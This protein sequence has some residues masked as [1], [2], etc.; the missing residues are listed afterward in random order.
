ML[1]TRNM[2]VQSLSFSLYFCIL[3]F[4]HIPSL[5]IVAD[6]PSIS[7]E[8]H[9]V[10][11]LA[12][13]GCSVD[14]LE[15][16]E[17]EGFGSCGP[18]PD[19]QSLMSEWLCSLLENQS[20]NGVILGRKI[21]ILYALEMVKN[22]MKLPI[23]ETMTIYQMLK[24]VER[25][26]LGINLTVPF[27]EEMQSHYQ[28]IISHLFGLFHFENADL[29]AISLHKKLN[30][31][32]YAIYL[33]RLIAGEPFVK[34][35]P[36]TWTCLIH[37]II[38]QIRYFQGDKRLQSLTKVQ[39]D[40]IEERLVH[41]LLHCLFK[42]FVLMSIS[43]SKTANILLTEFGVE[44]SSLIQYEPF[45][46]QWREMVRNLTIELLAII[47]PKQEE[48][49]KNYEF[50][51][52]NKT[53]AKSKGGAMNRSIGIVQESFDMDDGSFYFGVEDRLKLLNVDVLEFGGLD[54]AFM[55]WDR[56]LH[57]LG[58]PAR[59]PHDRTRSVHLEGFCDALKIF[60]CALG[61][62][63][64]GAAR[65]KKEEAIRLM[66]LKQNN[67]A[68]GLHSG[69]HG[70]NNN[71]HHST[72]GV[73]GNGG[74]A[75]G[76]LSGVRRMG[77]SI[78]GFAH[79]LI[80]VPIDVSSISLTGNLPDSI[81]NHLPLPPREQLP[82]SDTLMEIF[83]PWLFDECLDILVKCTYTEQVNRL[84]EFKMAFGCLAAIFL[85]KCEVGYL[86]AFAE[87][88]LSTFYRIIRI[89]FGVK[90]SQK[91]RAMVLEECAKGCLFG[92]NLRGVNC[93]IPDFLK[94]ME[95]VVGFEK[96]Q[97]HRYT[98]K[99]HKW[100]VAVFHEQEAN[101]ALTIGM[102]LICFA[103]HFQSL[104]IVPFPNLKGDADNDNDGNDGNGTAS[105]SKTDEPDGDD[106]I[107]KFEEI[108]SRVCDVFFFLAH[109][110]NLPL[111]IV[112]TVIWGSVLL[113]YDQVSSTKDLKIISCAIK[114]IVDGTSVD[115]LGMAEVATRA[116]ESLSPIC[117]QIC[118]IDS[119]LV[120][121]KLFGPF[122]QNML[123]FVKK[124]A[125]QDLRSRK[126]IC[127]VSTHQIYCCLEWMFRFPPSV[128][129]NDTLMSDYFRVLHESL[130]LQTKLPHKRSLQ[131]N[132]ADK[133]PLADLVLAAQTSKMMLFH[134]L[135]NFP[136]PHDSGAI[137]SNAMDDYK[138]SQEGNVFLAY[139]SNVLITAN[140]R[141]L[142]HQ[143]GPEPGV[144]FLL[145]DESGKFAWNFTPC[146]MESRPISNVAE[147][148]NDAVP[149]L[150]PKT[151]LRPMSKS[152][153]APKGVLQ[154]NAVDPKKTTT[155]TSAPSSSSTSRPAPPPPTVTVDGGPST[156]GSRSSPVSPHSP[157]LRRNV[158]YKKRFD[159]EQR[160]R[161][162]PP[163][164]GPPSQSKEGKKGQNGQN[165]SNSQ[166]AQTARIHN[167]NV[168]LT[169][170]DEKLA[171]VVDKKEF[172]MRRDGDNKVD[173]LK[174]VLNYVSRELTPPAGK[175]S[176]T[177]SYKK[178]IRP[179][180]TS[181]SNNA[182]AA[183][184]SISSF[185]GS[186]QP[187][188]SGSG[189][190]SSKMSNKKRTNSGTF[191]SGHMTD[192]NRAK[193]AKYMEEQRRE[194][195]ELYRVYEK[196]REQQLQ[197]LRKLE[198]ISV[199]EDA[200]G[201][202]NAET[203]EEG[204]KSTAVS[205]AASARNELKIREAVTGF[206]CS[207]FLLGH[208]GIL[209][210]GHVLGVKDSLFSDVTSDDVDM[211]KSGK[212]SVR[213]TR[214]M[215]PPGSSSGDGTKPRS[216]AMMGTSGSGRSHKD[217]K[218][219]H[220]SFSSSSGN[221][222]PPRQTSGKQYRLDPY[223]Y[224]LDQN[225]LAMFGNGDKTFHRRTH[226]LDKSSLEREKHKIGVVYVG[227]DQDEQRLILANESGSISYRRFID[228]LGWTVDL[229]RH[230]GFNGAMNASTTGR[231][232]KYYCTATHEMAFH[233]AT[234]MPTNHSDPQ[235][236]EKK[237]HIGNDQVNIIWTDSGR[238]YIIDTIYSHFNQAQI[239]I[240]PLN[241]GLYRIKIHRKAD[242][243]E[244][245]P[246]RNNMIIRE[247]LLSILVRITSLYA[248]RTIRYAASVYTRPFVERKKYLDEAI[249]KNSHK[250]HESILGAFFPYMAASATSA[251]S[252]S[253]SSFST[254]TSTRR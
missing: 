205:T 84:G 201:D 72:L 80:S 40:A 159:K 195:M 23:S 237:K 52:T 33:L 15:N 14:K 158:G 132:V 61:I 148:A 107:A 24:R 65:K 109:F 168:T 173:G 208:L 47:S 78:Y 199:V 41:P 225:L 202:G 12:L 166:N 60:L 127:A 139:D 160:D 51:E 75:V 63:E 247:H 16:V 95:S 27:K 17:R 90:I 20:K 233:I 171:N 88:Y 136:L 217:R 245:G 169:K 53:A 83:G 222:H 43:D 129:L 57:L 110:D 118:D 54:E 140:D 100:S 85:T 143:A 68:N 183:T 116:I 190:G 125:N 239:V 234:K 64:R 231:Y 244:F 174:Q 175:V 96:M 67:M 26:I 167:F 188:G 221:P 9:T 181:S 25:W 196:Q 97:Q 192:K 161:P 236:T 235:Q 214:P 32:S 179:P 117:N 194:E 113:I 186:P 216:S 242:V 154:S 157:S 212:S 149:V 70:N 98:A 187:K 37:G 142:A 74:T 156:Q 220:A 172:V 246:L 121:D 226:L 56:M 44:T 176:K 101:D 178:R 162:S 182:A 211:S 249:E 150:L 36:E 251:S 232:A 103:A 1:M 111:S 207:R 252:S 50:H 114:A 22:T 4:Y 31:I 164:P 93:L 229:L 106:G 35:S 55:I 77:S 62:K 92:K 99:R 119:Q 184:S 185:S 153:S 248:N 82:Q 6:F 8:K 59:N 76:G 29:N 215:S 71:H 42:S 238:E 10:N 3:M 180:T 7:A 120:T 115:K 46:I 240:Y 45:V 87:L 203:K 165:E 230:E 104:D 105:E 189:S 94:A 177:R 89:S 123:Q 170:T 134:Y 126:E 19:I 204:A 223:L 152:Q 213:R 11:I 228:K 86:G 151:M 66:K 39:S 34:L 163:R 69:H 224:S 193:L 210:P 227:P 124:A 58:S 49:E 2:S 102:S 79:S 5:F 133:H 28:R 206:D 112:N 197:R 91:I 38:Q 241:N 200:D 219:R 253:H 141:I 18:P 155:T 131:Q 243:G 135:G 137:S 146:S 191:P 138:G 30:I 130:C 48:K 73:P 144:R 81:R 13:C 147:P 218:R 198:S 209:T 108:T 145:R 21:Y 122:L 128:L 254:S 250:S